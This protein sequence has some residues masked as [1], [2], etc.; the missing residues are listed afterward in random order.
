M[1]LQAKD[2]QMAE[3]MAKMV[4]NHAMKMIEWQKEHGSKDPDIDFFLPEYDHYMIP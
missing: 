4:E 2:K 3:T 1:R